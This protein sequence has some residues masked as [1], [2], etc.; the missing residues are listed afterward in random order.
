[1]PQIKSAKKRV[2]VSARQTTENRLHRTRAR[3][4]LKKVRTMLASGKVKEAAS[5]FTVAQKYLDKA[6]KVNAVHGNTAARAKSRLARDL[7]NAG[8]KEALVGGTKA[9]SPATTKRK[10]KPAPPKTAATK[11]KRTAPKAADAK[12]AAAAKATKPKKSSAK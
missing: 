5:E 7:K 9:A 8:H 12:P 11:T 10:T 6:T 2:R 4:A 1:M 3:S